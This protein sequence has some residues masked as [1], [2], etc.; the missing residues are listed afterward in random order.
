MDFN[1]LLGSVVTVVAKLRATLE[2]SIVEVFLICFESNPHIKRLSKK[3]IKHLKMN[4]DLMPSKDLSNSSVSKSFWVY[5][6]SMKSMTSTTVLRYL[7]CQCGFKKIS[8][9]FLTKVD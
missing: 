1:D 9:R 4:A 8:K 7:T 5:F 2:S 6:K 3:C